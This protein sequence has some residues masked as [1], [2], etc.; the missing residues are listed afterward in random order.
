MAW[1][2]IEDLAFEEYEAVLAETVPVRVREHETRPSLPGDSVPALDTLVSISSE[3][4]SAG[5]STGGGQVDGTGCDALLAPSPPS[6]ASSGT[7][8]PGEGHAVSTMSTTR[9]S[10]SAE[11]PVME[12]GAGAEATRGKRG[13][14]GDFNAKLGGWFEHLSLSKRDKAKRAEAEMTG[15][16]SAATLENESFLTFSYLP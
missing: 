10:A 12:G 15:D 11:V 2:R 13:G 6:T 16:G 5:A 4:V 1:M 7:A 3:S 14:D 8:V 9:E